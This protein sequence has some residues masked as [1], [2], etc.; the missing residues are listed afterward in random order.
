MRFALFVLPFLPALA[1]AQPECPTERASPNG[2]HCCP[3]G[4]RWS[5][6]TSGCVA[7]AAPPAAVDPAQDQCL[8]TFVAAEPDAR[9]VVH[10]EGKSCETPCT[11]SLFAVVNRITVTGDAEFK[12][13]LNL[14]P[15]AAR[16]TSRSATAGC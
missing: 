11:L 8:V 6:E 7:L 9:Y 3:T 2:A 4:Q 14:A 15:G 12:Q 13:T 5:Q 16:V 10:A 1:F